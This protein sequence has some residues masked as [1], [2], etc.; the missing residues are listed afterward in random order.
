MLR[1]FLSHA[2]Y[3]LAYLKGER[4]EAPFPLGWEVGL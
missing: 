2:R 4:A 1:F 3:G